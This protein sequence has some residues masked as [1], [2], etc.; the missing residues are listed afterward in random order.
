VRVA[1][2]QLKAR[3]REALLER[4]VVLL[5]APAG[6]G[7]ICALA[8]QFEPGN[9]Q[10]AGNALAWIA[11]DED[12]DPQRLFACLIGAGAVRPALAHRPGGAPRSARRK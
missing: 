2:P 1:R 11:L 5:L 4:R 7:K 10:L 9:A 8:A 12:D 3:L 6:F